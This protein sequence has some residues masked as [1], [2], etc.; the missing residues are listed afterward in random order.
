MADWIFISHSS[1][2]KRLAQVICEY[3]SDAGVSDG[4]FFCSSYGDP[5][6]AG[7][8][9]LEAIYDYMD[10]AWV[11]VE[12]ISKSFFASERCLMEVGY[13]T[14]RERHAQQHPEMRRPIRFFPLVVPPVTYRRVNEKLHRR[15][16]IRLDSRS[17]CTTFAVQ[18]HK[19]LSDLGAQLDE[20]RWRDKEA[21]FSRACMDAI[22]SL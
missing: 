20:A 22:S 6:G 21:T 13:A 2:D 1:K 10:R 14:A 17:Q 18:L 3:L 7:H 5:I 12:L 4:D 16:S 9:D 19:A 15:Q 8:D 11:I